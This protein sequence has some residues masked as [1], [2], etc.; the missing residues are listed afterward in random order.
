VNIFDW[1]DH[2]WFVSGLAVLIIA[3]GLAQ[4]LANVGG[5]RGSE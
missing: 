4:M 5:Q 3:C 1:A 2:H